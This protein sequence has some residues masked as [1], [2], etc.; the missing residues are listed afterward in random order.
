MKYTD[1]KLTIII[2]TRNRSQSLEYT[3]KTCISQDYEDLSILISDNASSDST[4]EI[5]KS[6]ND[7][8]VRYINTSQRL[9]MT[10]NWEFAL[11][12]VND[13]YVSFIGDDDG[14]L[15][16]AAKNIASI[17]K[18]TNTKAISWNKAEY[19]WPNH[20]NSSL[21]NMLMI[22]VNNNL[23]EFPSKQAIKHSTRFWLPYNKLPTLYNSFV[24]YNV[25]NAC[26]EAGQPFFRSVTPDVYSGLALLKV[27][28]S[29][30]Y[31][32]RPFS[33]N[34]S[35]AFSNGASSIYGSKLEGEGSIFMSEIDLEQN[36]LFQVIPGAV[37]SNIAEAFL[38]ANKYCFEDKLT[39][40]HKLIVK[41]ILRDIY[42]YLPER[43][44]QSLR[45]L[46]NMVD[47]IN[48][49][50]F[51]EKTSRSIEFNNKEIAK[52]TS[53][54]SIINNG[55]LILDAHSL[56]VGNIDDACNLV[57]KILGVY[58]IPSSVETYSLFTLGMT[59]K[60]RDFT[61][62]STYKD[63]M[64]FLKKYISAIFYLLLNKLKLK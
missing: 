20:P 3:I 6:I 8:R 35:S 4:M 51:T 18:E 5:V 14:F 13:G 12:H 28:D 21:K 32:S 49:R 26:R 22:P 60:C 40:N 19:H 45:E 57:G 43:R 16:N 47:S 61:I 2:P 42:R 44:E 36:N 56:N 54:K 33:V 46:F 10:K 52:E 29:Y 63:G 38:Q 39:F 48:L 24:S 27:M 7:P 62:Y 15:P 30:L 53:K 11:S 23:L 37:Y 59:K 50:K 17:I 31:S 25:I 9:S 34:G 58:R 64:F 1:P 55:N 41:L